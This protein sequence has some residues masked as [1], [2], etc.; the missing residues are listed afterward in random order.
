MKTRL[1]QPSDFPKM[2]KLWQTA[3]LKIKSFQIE[4]KEALSIIKKNTSSCFILEH[5]RKIIGNVFGAFNGRRGWIY[6]LVIHPKYQRRGYGS[7][8]LQKAEKALYTM[9]TTRVLLGVWMS[10]KKY[11]RFIK[12]ADIL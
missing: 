8:L 4:K 2:Y 7:I 9:G 10:D 3:G 12:K 6:H 5:D 1:I 11:Y